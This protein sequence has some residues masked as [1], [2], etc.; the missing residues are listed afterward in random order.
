[1]R[2]LD[3]AN[4]SLWIN[5][6]VFA[7]SAGAV[8]QAGTRIAGYADAIARMTGIGH[9]AVGL[10]LLGGVTSL[11]EIAVSLFSAISHNPVLAVNNL[12]GGVAMQKAILAGAD[13]LIGKDALTVVVSSPA[14]LLQGALSILMLAVAAA[15]IA[16]RDV[17]VFGIG[18]WSWILLALYAF[19]I[20]TLAATEGR[21]PWRPADPVPQREPD[22]SGANG[23]TPGNEPEDS[24]ATIIGK[25][26]VAAI[27]ILLAGFLLS[28][29][30]DALA[31]QTG[32]GQ[33][34]VGAVLLGFSTSLPELSTVVSAMRL[35][36]YEMA[37]SDILGTNLFNVA[38]I[39]LI[40]AAYPGQPV[41]N[42]VGN[43]SLFVA[44]LGIVLTVIYL[45]GLIERRNHTIARMGIDSLAILAVYAIGLFLLYRMR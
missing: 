13:A 28:Q 21:R 3:F 32:L 19:S 44:V 37:I 5:L 42:E 4:D 31:K 12:L 17:P 24:P 11:P 36:Q 23:D 16:V 14:L 39:F 2:L 18:I 7:A 41:L 27:V 1:M 6:T 22:A 26:A 29:T 33:S 30:G 8:W 15:A 9:M 35:R 25:T 34:F 20:W 38:L 45:V 40:D 10:V 43:F